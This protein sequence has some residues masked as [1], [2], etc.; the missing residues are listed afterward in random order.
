MSSARTQLYFNSCFRRCSQDK[1]RPLPLFGPGARR[2]FV[3]VSDS[4][5]VSVCHFSIEIHQY[6]ASGAGSVR[7][8]H[9]PEPSCISILV[10]DDVAKIN[11]ALF[12]YSAPA[13]V[14]S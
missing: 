3:P 4:E 6:K 14:E 10:S 2:E 5:R 12:L 11:S 13:L 9:L 7:V 8:C 1:F